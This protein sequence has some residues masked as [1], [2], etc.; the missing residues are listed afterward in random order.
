MNLK[1]TMLLSELVVSNGKSVICC[2]LDWLTINV[3]VE[4]QNICALSNRLRAN[5]PCTR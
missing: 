4:F 1:E 3:N 2:Y 5:Y